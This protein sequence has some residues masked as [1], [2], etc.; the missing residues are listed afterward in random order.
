MYTRPICIA[1]AVSTSAA[2][3]RF[4]KARKGHAAELP[5]LQAQSTMFKPPRAA[6]G[7][8]CCHMARIL[9]MPIPSRGPGANVSDFK[10]VSRCSKAKVK[11]EC[12]Y[13][14]DKFKHAISPFAGAFFRV[15]FESNPRPCWALYGLDR[16]P[17]GP[18]GTRG[19]AGGA[20]VRASW[21]IMRFRG[22]VCLVVA[23]GNR[24]IGFFGLLLSA[25]Y[26]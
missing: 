14:H 8:G 23:I 18:W 20:L 3:S 17:C 19:R 2:P 21:Q 9:R 7:Q 16:R 1:C 5:A 22:S 25:D 6:Y 24:P 15:S 26:R 4:A 10:N 13:M 11:I 12:R